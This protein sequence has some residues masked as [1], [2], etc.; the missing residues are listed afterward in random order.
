MNSVAIDI[1][2]TSISAVVMDAESE[3]IKRSWTIPNPGF[4]ETPYA[5]ERIQ[6]PDRI[7]GAS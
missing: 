2:T 7:V 1:G 4:L 5:W 6:S 3:R